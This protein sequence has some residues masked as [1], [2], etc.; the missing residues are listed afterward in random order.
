MGIFDGLLDFIRSYA[1]KA[2]KDDVLFAAIHRILTEELGWQ[3]K[4]FTMKG[5]E[6]EA[7]YTNPQSPIHELEI[8]AK[9]IGNQF[10]LRLEAETLHREKMEDFLEGILGIEFDL[11]E[12]IKVR[13]PLDYYVTDTLDLKN[14]NELEEKLINLI[15]ELEKR[16]S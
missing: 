2:Q 1:V 3:S 13:F 8:E 14:E 7:S 10:I 4:S 16:V 15:R 11:D 9:R 6:H 12:E 5:D